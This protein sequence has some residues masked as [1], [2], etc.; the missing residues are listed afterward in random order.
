MTIAL[1]LVVGL[2][3]ARMSPRNSKWIDCAV[4]SAPALQRVVTV[5]LD[6]PNGSAMLRVRLDRLSDARPRWLSIVAAEDEH[7]RTRRVVGRW[8]I[9]TT[10]EQVTITNLPKGV[11]VVDVSGS[12]S[13]QHAS[14]IAAVGEG[15]NSEVHVRLVPHHFRARVTVGHKAAAGCNIQLHNVAA[16]WWAELLTDSKGRIDVDSWASGAFEVKVS[17]IKNAVTASRTILVS[18]STGEI[19]LSLPDHLVKGVITD[20]QHRPV[21]DANINV[22]AI[23]EDGR[24][25]RL[26][27]VSDAAGQFAFDG[28]GAGVH[29]LAV[30]ADGF[31]I[32]DPIVVKV[33]VQD[34][35]AN[36]PIV[37]TRGIPAGFRLRWAD[38]NHAVEYAEVVNVT[39]GHVRARTISSNG[40]I[41]TV[42]TIYGRRS[43]LYVFLEKDH[44]PSSACGTSWTM[45]SGP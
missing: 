26:R 10:V 17:R 34:Q 12:A 19:Q 37:L 3:A 25:A 15:D 40:G 38:D 28:I 24:I 8:P 23:L 18:D 32:P 35:I 31:V 44:W 33:G 21:R 41:A 9:G 20:E 11:Y 45:Q 4:E 1:A 43:V 16:D 42:P 13:M 36:V 30:F 5:H 2:A 22:S 39:D 6:D 27:A 7:S 29:E 14:Q